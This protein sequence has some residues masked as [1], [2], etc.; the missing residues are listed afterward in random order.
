MTERVASRGRFFFAAVGVVFFAALPAVSLAAFGVSPP[1]VNTD[2]LTRGAK[3]TQTIYLV[4]DQPNEDL[5]IKADLQIDA[6]ARSWISLDKGF[7]FVIPKGMRQFPVEFVVQV[8]K[9]TALGAYSGTLVFTGAPSQV[10]QVTIALGAQ[11]AVN[12]TVGEGV[13]RKFTV[14]VIKFLDI[15]EGWN[16]KVYVKFNNEGNVPERFTGATFELLDQYGA[17]RLAYAQEA[18]E[19][20]ETPPFT[21]QEYFVEFPIDF[22]LGIGQ[23]WGVVNFYQNGQ[24]V[25]SQKTI[26]N[27]L[28]RGSLSSSLDQFFRT[29]SES[30]WQYALGVL[31]V[32]ILFSAAW[33]TRRRRKTA[34]VSTSAE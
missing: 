9:E 18:K 4:Q 22:H 28:K 34:R 8:P 24:V 21:V 14:P 32:V 29:L 25:A 26:F 20:P 1:F 3:Y 15:E 19:L 5:R 2:H 33:Q 12:L 17:A 11:V 13:Y 16:P 27:V 6:R 30:W 7:E 23:Y 10:G 31:I